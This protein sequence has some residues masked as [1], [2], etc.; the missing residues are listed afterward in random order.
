M[1]CFCP[2]VTLFIFQMTFVHCFYICPPLISLT[3][4]A[5]SGHI[6][7]ETSLR[8]VCILQL[9][10]PLCPRPQTLLQL[11]KSTSRSIHP[12][13]LSRILCA[14]PL[15]IPHPRG[16]NPSSSPCWL[17]AH[18][19]PWW[20]STAKIWIR[21]AWGMSSLRKSSSLIG[22]DLLQPLLP[23]PSRQKLRSCLS[24]RRIIAGLWL[25]SS[26]KWS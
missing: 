4:Q 10:S 6:W 9:S 24:G 18:M 17:C 14:A 19:D 26:L 11:P 8:G 22:S 2:Q 12:P 25:C 13:N 1:K 16:A 20:P 5:H 3:G 23:C 15:L 7:W 21:T